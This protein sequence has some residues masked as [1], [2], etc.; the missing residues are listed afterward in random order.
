ML[1]DMMMGKFSDAGDG[2][3][4]LFQG[5]S[6]HVNAKTS[7]SNKE[8]ETCWLKILQAASESRKIKKKK[9]KTEIQ[10]KYFKQV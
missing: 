3:K 4:D 9:M 8:V 10:L 6:S 5:S 2:G 7:A 1:I